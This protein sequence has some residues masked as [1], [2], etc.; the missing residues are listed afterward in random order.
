MNRD[1]NDK[2]N[3]DRNIQELLEKPNKKLAIISILWILIIIPIAFFIT[4]NFIAIFIFLIWTILGI[5]L[6]PKIARKIW[7]N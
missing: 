1:F 3:F 7:K 5:C 2:E 4:V 6:S